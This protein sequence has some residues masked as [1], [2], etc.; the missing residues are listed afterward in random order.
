M[1]SE[2]LGIQGLRNLGIRDFKGF[3]EIL[4]DLGIKGSKGKL[5]DFEE[6]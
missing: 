5:R 2:I 4:R 1:N 6:F 3:L